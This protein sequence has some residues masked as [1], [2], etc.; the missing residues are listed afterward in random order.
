MTDTFPKYAI[1]NHCDRPCLRLVAQWVPDVGYCYMAQS[2]FPELKQYNGMRHPKP[3]DVRD[4]GFEIIEGS[5]GA[6]FRK[7]GQTTARY[8]NGDWREWQDYENSCFVLPYVEIEN[9]TIGAA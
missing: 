9:E 1:V 2:Y 3:T 4:F 7:T 6:M 5:N 8:D